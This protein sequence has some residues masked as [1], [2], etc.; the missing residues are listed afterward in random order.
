MYAKP[1]IG[2]RQSEFQSV[3]RVRNPWIQSTESDPPP[4]DLD[5]GPHMELS[6][7]IYNK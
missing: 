2:R 4:Q 6:Y 3:P 1:E 7:R 5:L